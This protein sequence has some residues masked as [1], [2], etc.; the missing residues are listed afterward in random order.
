MTTVFLEE[1]RTAIY[2]RIARAMGHECVRRGMDVMMVKPSGFNASTFGEFLARQGNGIYLSMTGA[3]IVQSRAADQAEHFFE[4]FPGRVIF[5]HQDAIL[6]GLTFEAALARLQAYQRVAHRSWHLCI[7]PDTITALNAVGIDN[8]TLVPHASE[9]EPSPALGRDQCHLG[10]TF[11]GH[12]LPFDYQ[13]RLATRALEHMID[14]ALRQRMDNLAAPAQ[15]LLCDYADRVLEHFGPADETGATRWAYVHWLRSQFTQRT[16]AL[17][18][19]VL[20][21]AQLPDLTVVGGDPAYL[22]RVDRCLTLSGAG[23]RHVPPVYEVGAVRELFCRSACNINITSLQFDHAVVNRFHDVFLA[24]GLCLTDAR[25]GV[26]E[27][28]REHAELTF[29]TV[30]ELRERVRYFSEPRNSALRAALIASVQRDV[31]AH[32]GYGRLGE[33]VQAALD[34]LGG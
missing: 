20:E 16:M 21:Q 23:I 30:E 2:D 4:I 28:T 8:T 31:L 6:G 14:T 13:P 10:A 26:S 18:G 17:R 24:G 12:A 5:V 3:N 33:H 34:A 1:S 27:L 15:P 9:F 32:S 29:R 22:H 11:V 7:E 25:S 19:W